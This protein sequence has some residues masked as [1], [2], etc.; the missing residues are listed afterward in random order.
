MSDL[1]PCPFCGSEVSVKEHCFHGLNNTYGVE[2]THCRVQTWQFYDTRE[3]AI[4]AWNTRKGER[5]E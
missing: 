2:C 5:D 1:K 4:K 3:D